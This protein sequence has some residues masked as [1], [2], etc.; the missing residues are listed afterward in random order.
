[1][2][3]PRRTPPRI[4]WGGLPSAALVRAGAG[5]LLGVLAAT[6]GAFVLGEYQ[7][8]GALPI[9]AGLLY[10]AVIAEV[11]VEVGRRRTLPVALA[12]GAMSA[13]GLLWAGWISAG[14]GLEPITSGAKLAAAVGFTV[15][16]ARTFDWRAWRDARRGT[17]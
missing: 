1:M 9:A 16:M 8:E 15:A 5:L 4:E 13:G 14:E 2:D 3:E 10:G 17:S 12:T 6:F 7:F 11:V